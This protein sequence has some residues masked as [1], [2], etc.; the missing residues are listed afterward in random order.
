[1]LTGFSTRTYIHPNRIRK[2]KRYFTSS[3]FR[4]HFLRL[5]SIQGKTASREFLH[6][7]TSIKWYLNW[8]YFNEL[9][10]SKWIWDGIL[11]IKWSHL[12]P[13]FFL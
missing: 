12:S 10:Q 7:Q 4:P 1:L 8:S 6:L 3:P 5:K 9:G 2:R 11:G 13:W